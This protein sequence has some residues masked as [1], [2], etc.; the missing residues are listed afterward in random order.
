MSDSDYMTGT[1]DQTIN[2][3]N[4]GETYILSFYQAMDQ[5]TEISGA[6]VITTPGA[7]S[8]NWQVSLGSDVQTSAM[9]SANGVSL[10][11]TPWTLQTMTFTA[12]A[13]SE[14]LSFFAMGTGAPPMAMLDGVDLEEAP[15]PAAVGLTG[16][17]IALLGWKLIAL[18]KKRLAE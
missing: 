18:R 4:P 9:M 17:G 14:V 13:T 2:G 5:D 7:V 6:S 1:I 16:I 15:E 11:F 10:T 12:S 8:G 3:L